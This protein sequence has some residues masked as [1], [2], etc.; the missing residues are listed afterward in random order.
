MTA[1]VVE[2]KPEWDI[3]LGEYWDTV[4]S[5]PNSWTYVPSTYDVEGVELV[6]PKHMKLWMELEVWVN[7][8]RHF[9]IDTQQVGD[10]VGDI[11]EYGINTDCPVVYYDIDTGERINGAHRNEVSNKLNIPGWMMQ[12]VRFKNEAAKIRFATQ[13]NKKRKD[14]YSL[15]DAASIETAVRELANIPEQ[16]DIHTDE[17]IRAEVIKLG[18]GAISDSKIKDIANKL[19]LERRYSGEISEGQ[20][21]QTWSADMVDTFVEEIGKDKWIEDVFL[22]SS[23]ITLYINVLEFASREGSII[24]AAE[25]ACLSNKPLHFLLSVPVLST[26]K[27]KTTRQKV[28]TDRL[29]TLERKM[30][31]IIGIDLDRHT[32]QFPWNHPDSEHRFMPQDMVVEDKY[33]LVELDR[34]KL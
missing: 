7:P 6:G 19:I 31:N 29:K 13:S 25:Q 12:A 8:G 33:N 24:A 20:R 22:N 1:K 32:N 28:F 15:P 27:L 17:D 34:E 4:S 14:V 30:C 16:S 26:E 10:L 11:E 3:F 18:K 5:N 23:E 2:V 21:F 9:G